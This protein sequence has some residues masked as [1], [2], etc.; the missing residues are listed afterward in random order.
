MTSNL[1]SMLKNNRKYR[2]Y[3]TNP[4]SESPNTKQIRMFKFKFFKHCLRFELFEFRNCLGFRVLKLGF[5]RVTA[6][7]RGAG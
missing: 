7:M 2:N 1:R 4:K 3:H 5:G 6:R